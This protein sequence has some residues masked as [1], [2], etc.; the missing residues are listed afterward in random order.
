MFDQPARVRSTIDA[1]L[2][3]LLPPKFEPE[4]KLWLEKL[5][6]AKL[7]PELEPELELVGVLSVPIPPRAQ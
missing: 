2:E 6:L 4:L 5:W 1:T 7:S 3:L